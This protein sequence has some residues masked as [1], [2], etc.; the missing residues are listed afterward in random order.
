MSHATRKLC[1][2]QLAYW[3]PLTQAAAAAG[4]AACGEDGSGGGRGSEPV[5][6]V[7]SAEPAG[8]TA[9]VPGDADDCAI[10]VHP[11]NAALSLIIGTDKASRG[12]M[13]VWDLLG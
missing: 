6:G 1:S 12:G 5:V 4:L 3:R 7:V 2:P 13:F 11:A 9:S 8:S 10:W